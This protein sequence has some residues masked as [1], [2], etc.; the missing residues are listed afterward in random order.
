[1][2][3]REAL[4][5]ERLAQHKTQAA[6]IK[7]IPMSVSHYSEIETGYAKNGKEADI[8]S[9][10]LILLLKS[11]H[12]D[13]IK[14]FESVN[15]SYKIDERARMIEDISNQLSIA[16]NNN[17]LERVEKITHELE[18]I[19]TVPKITYYRAV[20]IRAYLKDEMTSMD[21]AT[22][23]KINQYIYQKDNWVTDNEALTIFG[24][25]MPISDPDILIARMGKV[26]RYYKNLEN[27]PAT[28]QRRVS[29]VCVNYLYTALCIRKIDKYVSETMALIR[30]LPFDDRFGLKILITQYFE[31]MKKGDKKSMQQLKDVLRHAGLTKLANRL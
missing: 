7:N 6:W 13:I 22:R 18:N 29:T 25:S 2:K 28:F 4:R 20:L 27:C 16:F 10:K 31:D 9:E 1:M 17:D 26:L 11:N 8:D 12:V 21:K 19:P 15:G 14:F 3:I 24:N 30:T 23:A 5:K